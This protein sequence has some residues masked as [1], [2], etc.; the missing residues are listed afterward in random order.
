MAS[1][2]DGRTNIPGV[3]EVMACVEESQKPNK[4]MKAAA[5]KPQKRMKA[6]AV[7][8]Q[9]PMKAAVKKASMKPQPKAASR[10]PNK[11]GYSKIL[12]KSV[13]R[14][15]SKGSKSVKARGMES[16]QVDELSV[17]VSNTDD[18]V[19]HS[20]GSRSVSMHSTDLC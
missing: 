16:N 4:P 17:V 5:V 20:F 18:N 7:K 2:S 14:M 13:V 10:R 9:K 3:Y 11:R 8:P 12:S 15:K 1:C 6:S 19:A